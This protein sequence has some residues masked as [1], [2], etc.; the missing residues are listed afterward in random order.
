VTNTFKKNVILLPLFYG[1][2]FTAGGL[3]CCCCLFVCCY[4]FRH[5]RN[6][7]QHP[8]FSNRYHDRQHGVPYWHASRGPRSA[9]SGAARRSCTFSELPQYRLDKDQ[10]Q[11]PRLVRGIRLE[12]CVVFREAVFLFEGDRSR[13]PCHAGCVNPHARLN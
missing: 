11:E 2:H 5:S 9:C 1:S 10:H 8:L 7:F 6:P 4:S 13:T 3:D 12:I